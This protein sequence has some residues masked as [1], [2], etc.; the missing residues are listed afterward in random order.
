[1]Q[2][3]RAADYAVRVMIHLAGLPPATC[4]THGDL[5]AA[6]DCPRQ[7]LAKVL[8]RMSR[9]RL[10]VSRRGN[11]GGFELPEDRRQ[12]TMLEIIEAMEGPVALNL[13]LESASACGR[14]PSCPAHLVWAQAQAALVAVL[15]SA[16]IE[17]LAAEAESI[18]QTREKLG[19]IAKWT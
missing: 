16:T 19:G 18:R 4:V 8:Q 14:Q 6:V 12:A 2:M 7:F 11:I 9:A 10:I 5:A 1:M 3:T 17:E 13:C 15:R